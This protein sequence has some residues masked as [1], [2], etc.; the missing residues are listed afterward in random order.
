MENKRKKAIPEHFQVTSLVVCVL[1]WGGKGFN[2][3]WTNGL[4]NQNKCT[5]KDKGA[6]QSYHTLIQEKLQALV[7]FI[8]LIVVLEEQSGY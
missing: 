7:Q 8:S 4:T 2:K 6:F 5:F 3:Q 1:K